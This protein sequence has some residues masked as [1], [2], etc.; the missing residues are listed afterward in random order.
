MTHR[1]SLSGGD[2][3]VAVFAPNFRDTLTSNRLGD[4][5]RVRV[6]KEIRAAISSTDPARPPRER[7]EPVQGVDDVQKLYATNEIRIWCRVVRGLEGYEL[8][9]VFDVDPAHRYSRDE[10]TEVD[11]DVRDVL[12]V[13]GEVDDEQSAEA[14]LE[15]YDLLYE[16]DVGDLVETFES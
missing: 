14:F 4:E 9:F 12:A 11:Q 15:Q 3:Y 7:A 8:L 5:A 6:L 13:V 16:D 10:L 1:R 2:D